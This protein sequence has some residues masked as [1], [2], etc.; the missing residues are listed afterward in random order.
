MKF[1]SIEIIDN[2]NQ[3]RRVE[4]FWVEDPDDE[5]IEAADKLWQ[6]Y[7]RRLIATLKASNKSVPE[8]HH[9]SW[10]WKLQQELKR[11]SLFKCF[12]VL[13]ADY[14]PQGL[15]LLNYGREYLSRLP[16]QESRLLTY[17][18]YIESAPWNLSDYSDKP[19]YDGVG[20]A[21]YRTTIQY[22]LRLGF[23]GRVGLH[24]LPNVEGFYAKYCKKI[25]C[26]ADPDCGG[27]VYF[28]STPE[29]SL[30]FLK[31]SGK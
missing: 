20:A 9:W 25:N 12:G 23:E 2:L 3:G 11:D 30:S 24:S 1:E 5:C 8:H 26:G 18:T 27:L 4:A 31:G 13:D 22:S 29:T 10:D 16:G 7:R 19:R 21:L 28:E 6:V 17:L 14:E 15:M